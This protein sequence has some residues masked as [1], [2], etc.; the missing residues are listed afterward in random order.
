[1]KHQCQKFAFA[2]ATITM[3]I[4]A[5]FAV[6]S[7]N[8]TQLLSPVLSG[9][10]L[11]FRVVIQKAAF[12]LPVGIHSGALGTYNGLW[13][14]IGGRTNGLHG[15][16]PDPF[17]PDQQNTS[18]YVVNPQTGVVSSRSLR[19]PSSG[20]SRQEIDYLAVTSPESFQDGT[21]LYM[22]GG[23]GID[24]ATGTYGTKAVLTAFNL[25]GIVQWVMQPGNPSNNFVKNMRQVFNPIFQVTGGT[26]LKS[27]NV[28]QLIFGQNFT[29]VYTSGSNGN[30]TQVVREFQLK[31]SG[32]QLSVTVLPSKPAS[33]NP[34]YR[35]RDLNVVPVILNNHNTLTYGAVAYAGVF[36]NA[37]G[38]WTVP[39][40][41][42]SNGDS[43]MADPNLPSTFKQAMNQYVC[44]TANLYSRKTMST[45]N[46]FFGGLSYGYFSSGVFT[47]DSELPFI[48]QV[49]TVQMDKNGFFTQYIMNG[50]Y[51]TI[52]STQS[53]PGNTLL[54]GA[55]ADFIPSNIQ[56]YAN[57]VMDLDSI[58]QPTVIGYI[59][60]GIQSTVPNTSSDSDSAASPYVFTVTLIPQ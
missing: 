8:Q 22:A 27:G 38:A 30:Y 42:N 11:P 45:Y 55:G 21:T 10:S 29:G 7:P 17:P 1:M 52:I 32:G 3:S 37:G 24:T 15:F 53:N 48:N 54:F 33:P 18:V 26:M 9:N 23:Y 12:L 59:V 6:P 56:Q 51:P 49:T 50:E 39:V 2:L 40:V 19:D 20:L 31:D 13:I 43:V 36:T 25:P 60:G 5:A 28:I 41:I 4:G 16:G 35:R 47:T 44:A 57:G 46:V 34:N 14:F 58:R